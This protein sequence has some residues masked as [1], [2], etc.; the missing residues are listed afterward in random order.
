MQKS[1]KKRA[2]SPKYVS[3]SQLTL[4]GFEC[5]FERT[6]NLNK[7]WVV[8][9][10]LRPWD[11]ISGIYLKYQGISSTGRPPLNPRVII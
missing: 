4:E 2:A 7:R 9:A 6:L 10:K 5:L 8:L 11:E 1:H 3:P